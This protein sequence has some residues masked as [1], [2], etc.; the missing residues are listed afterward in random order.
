MTGRT[1][2]KYLRLFKGNAQL[3]GLVPPGCQW[4]RLRPLL[5]TGDWLCLREFIVRETRR[6]PPSGPEIPTTM[7]VKE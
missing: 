3:M 4:D 7:S 1:T 5:N 6:A 2:L